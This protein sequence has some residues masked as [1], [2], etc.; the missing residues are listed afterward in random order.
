MNDIFVPIDVFAK[1]DA[2]QNPQ[3]Y[4]REC[5]ERAIARNEAVKGK[6]PY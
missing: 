5:M 1:I 4:S 2:G 6:L 3:I